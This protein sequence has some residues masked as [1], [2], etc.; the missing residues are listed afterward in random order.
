[1]LGELVYI[2]LPEV[3]QALEDGAELAVIESVKAAADIYAPVTGEVLQVNE[4]LG[5]SPE[6]INSDPYGEGWIAR[7]RPFEK[8]INMMTPDQYQVMLEEITD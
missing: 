4:Q 8:L 6:I 7:V 5:E 2:E 1:M 3:G